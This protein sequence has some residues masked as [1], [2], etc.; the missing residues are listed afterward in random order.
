MGAALR[1][2]AK[3]LTQ[4]LRDRSVFLWGI[5]APLGLA[6][7]FSLLFAG[8]SDTSELDVSYAVADLDGGPSA[9]AFVDDVLGSIEEQGLFDIAAVGTAAEAEEL[10]ADGDVQ[11]AF[12]IPEGFS[13]AVERGESVGIEVIGNVDSPTMAQVAEAIAGQFAS[14]I[15]A[16]G[17]SIFTL[18]AV[19]G[20]T[21]DAEAAGELI[22]DV[23]AIPS[24]VRIGETDEEA[25]KQLSAE[26]FYSA[27]M[28]VLFLFLTVQFGILGLLE[29]RN[30]STM[31]RLLAAPIPRWSIIGGKAITSFVIGVASMTV[32]VVGTTLLLGAEWGNSWGVALLVLAAVFSALGI[33]FVLAAFAKTAEQAGNLQ[34]IVA[35]LLAMLGGTFFPLAQ[36]GGWLENVSLLTPHA[37]FLRGLGDLAAGGAV[38]EALPAAGAIALFG[39][40]T[41]ALGALGARRMVRP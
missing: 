21:P 28:A 14:E 26:T 38:A 8:V 1:I 30:N 20:E 36:A 18:F 25:S 10:A 9:R 7:I 4:R 41:L 27:G 13:A 3:D 29:E 19:R 31:A 39:L 34:S 15:N 33:M 40:V 24:P 6:A 11:A 35:F 32:L 17:T 22:D 16:V 12:V 37:W 5:V 23:M 2:A